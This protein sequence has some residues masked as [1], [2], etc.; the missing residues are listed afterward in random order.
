VILLRSHSGDYGKLSI[1]VS[2][3][4]PRAEAEDW[5]SAELI[6]GEIGFLGYQNELA[7]SLERGRGVR[8][9]RCLKAA[10]GS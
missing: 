3:Y 7:L 2:E 5:V 6:K 8:G 1:M 10:F 4:F 9:W